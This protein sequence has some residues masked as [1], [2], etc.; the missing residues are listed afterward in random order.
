[1]ANRPLI[2]F[3]DARR[4]WYWFWLTFYTLPF[5]SNR[6]SCTRLGQWAI[7][8]VTAEGEI[9]QTIPQNKSLCQALLDG[10]RYVP[11]HRSITDPAHPTPIYQKRQMACIERFSLNRK[12]FF[13]AESLPFAF[14]STLHTERD[15]IYIRTVD[16]WI[17]IC[18][19]PCKVPWKIT[20]PSLKSSTNYIVKWVS[21]C[22]RASGAS[23]RKFQ[24][25]IYKSWNMYYMDRLMMILSIMVLQ[26]VRFNC[27]KYVRKMI[28][29]FESNHADIY[30]ARHVSPHGK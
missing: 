24:I 30:C 23:I 29:T 7:G 12:H 26:G 28:K 9:L 10:H 1:M 20:L 8:Y 27:A 21:V 15:S 11:P 5:G 6:L 3:I 22:V 25:T 13:D 19:L 17:R 14:C 2:T 4:I 16:R 18:R